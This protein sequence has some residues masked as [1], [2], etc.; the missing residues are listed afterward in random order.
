MASPPSPKDSGFVPRREFIRDPKPPPN[1]FSLL[2]I[3]GSSSIRLYS[4]T[5][6]IVNSLRAFFR[7]ASLL[8]TYREDLNNQFFEFTLEG[9]PWS[10][11]KS[12][13]TERLLIEILSVISHHGYQFLSTVDYGRESDDRVALTFSR[14]AVFSQSLS[15]SPTPIPPSNGSGTTL[16]GKQRSYPFALS[17]S[18]MTCLRVICPP[19][20]STP[21][22]LQAVRGAWPRGVESEKKIG[23]NCFEFKLKGY[24]CKLMIFLSFPYR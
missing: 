13:A 21:A 16:S 3:S 14:P 19:L 22:I 18:S 2:A 6:S 7:Q 17:F 15:P 4:F 20:H 5:P 23:E 11:P 1:S 12:V 8:H 9:K 24:K 10:S